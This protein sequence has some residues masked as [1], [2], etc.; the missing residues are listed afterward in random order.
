M[1]RRLSRASLLLGAAVLTASLALS[2]CGSMRRAVGA[3]RVTPDEF[4]VVTKAPLVVPPEYNLRPPR[5]GEPRPQDLVPEDLAATALFTGYEN[6]TASD[7][8]QLLVA[9]MSR[10]AQDSSIRLEI[11]MENGVIQKSRGF[12]NRILFWRDGDTADEYEPSRRAAE[13]EI[14]R[15]ARLGEAATGGE[16]VEIGRGSKLPGL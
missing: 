2:G 3:E 9:K 4:R 10:G 5:P 8:E 7:A 12:A 11:D 14:E 16:E 15:R 1:T 6:S 13:E